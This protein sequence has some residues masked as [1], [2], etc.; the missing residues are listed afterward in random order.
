MRDGK[1]EK[2]ITKKKKKQEKRKEIDTI[3]TKE[4]RKI[5]AKHSHIVGICIT[6]IS[7]W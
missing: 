6:H 4:G 3:I 5:F 1:S 2:A 7:Y